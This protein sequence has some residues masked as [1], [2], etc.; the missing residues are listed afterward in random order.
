MRRHSLPQRKFHSGFTYVEIL[1]TLSIVGLLF[2]PMMQMF[3]HA[4]AATNES[5][6]ITTAVSLARWQIERLKNLSNDLENITILAGT[7][8]PP[9][10]EPPLELNDQF[11]RIDHFIN[12][13]SKPVEV[14]VS[15]R[16]DGETK[17]LAELY[18]L[19]AETSWIQ[20]K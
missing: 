12:E 8:W 1:V 15:V 5:R 9:P 16:R 20:P 14:R 18:T 13:A 3:T 6:D 7:M 4:M 2:V 10:E 11:W 19:I 17:S